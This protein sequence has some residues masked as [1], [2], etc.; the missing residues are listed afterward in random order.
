MGAMMNRKQQLSLR[1]RQKVVIAAMV[2]LFFV[3]L[4]LGCYQAD[5]KTWKSRETS[6]LSVE[7]LDSSFQT[8]QPFK[9]SVWPADEEHFIVSRSNIVIES[10]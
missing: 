9:M 7:P 4:A 10:K 3:L 5:D 2:V 6:V 8:N 1:R